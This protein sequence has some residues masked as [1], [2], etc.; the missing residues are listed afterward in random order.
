MI[1]ISSEELQESG[2][3]RLLCYCIS[4]WVQI[5]RRL[6]LLRN[7]AGCC[8]EEMCTVLMLVLA[9]SLT[10]FDSLCLFGGCVLVL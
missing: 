5:C 2:W 9:G 1:N 7:C 3:C 10:Q 6:V 4:L 8:M